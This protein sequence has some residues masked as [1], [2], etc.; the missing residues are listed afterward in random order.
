M[1]FGAAFYQDLCPWT[2]NLARGWEPNSQ[3]VSATPPVDISAVCIHSAA[4]K[5]CQY[6]V[7]N[8]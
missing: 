4:F 2:R 5:I 3:P 8:A 7:L 1:A 6:V